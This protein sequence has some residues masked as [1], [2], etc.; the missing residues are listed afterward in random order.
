MNEVALPNL[1][2]KRFIPNE[3]VH[4]KKDRILSYGD[5]LLLTSWQTLRPREDIACGISAYFMDDG[6]KVSLIYDREG[7]VVYWYCDIIHTVRRPEENALIFE[8]L[9][10]D[11]IV[12]TDGRYTIVDVDETAD[13]FETNLISKQQLLCA[14]RSLDRLLQLIARGEFSRLQAVVLQAEQTYHPFSFARPC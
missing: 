5:S 14:L 7:Q 4:L 11:V 13:A 8:D 9:L 10:I 12:Y 3:L 6:Y 2:R 1:Y